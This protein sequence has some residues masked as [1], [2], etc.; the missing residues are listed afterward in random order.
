MDTF[1]PPRLVFD[2]PNKTREEQV[3]ILESKGL[4]ISDKDQAIK[5][6]SQ[7]GYSKFFSH[8]HPYL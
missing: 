4:V 2:Y 3:V 8:L 6:L 7:I 5:I 1:I